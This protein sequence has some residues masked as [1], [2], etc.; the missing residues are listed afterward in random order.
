MAYSVIR[1]GHAARPH[2]R[3]T[4]PPV[5]RPEADGAPPIRG[6]IPGWMVAIILLAAVVPLGFVSGALARVTFIAGCSALGWYA[7]RQSAAIHL[8]TALTLFCFAPFVRRIIDLSAGFDPTGLM[9]VGPLMVLLA[10]AFDLWNAFI[11]GRPFAN[12]QIVPIVI[13][14]ACTLYAGTLS[15]FKWDLLNTASGL[16]KGFSP[17][18]YA[19]ALLLKKESMESLLE[20]AASAFLVILPIMGIYGIYQYVDPPEW[21]R[22]WMQSAT[23]TSAG[24]PVPYGVRT[25]S[26]MNSPGAFGTFTGVGL[27]LVL[28]LR[29]GPT[30]L[31]LT[32]PA[33]IAF[34]L[35]MYRT[36][37]L[38]T[39]AVTGFCLLFS[40]TR[41]RAVGAIGASI[42]M[43]LIALATP[44]S[45]VIVERFNSFTEGSN[46][47]SARERLDEFIT[48]WNMPTSNLF[49]VGFSNIDVGV[50][51]TMPVDGVFVAC[52]LSM[53]IIV[54]LICIYAV[55][56]A[57]ANAIVAAFGSE[58][59]T[60]I[61]AG[62][63]A[64]GSI[65]HFPLAEIIA[66]EA[67]FLFWT[68]V[69][70]VQGPQA[71][72]SAVP[73]SAQAEP[74]PARPALSRLPPAAT[75][76][77]T[78]GMKGRGF[79]AQGSGLP[80]RASGQ[81]QGS[82]ARALRRWGQ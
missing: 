46:D 13:V 20:A 38:S 57:C 24:Q 49:G 68:F 42:I 4:I 34:M 39:A 66:G 40:A 77:A 58:R 52:W 2:Q 1:Q 19:G 80:A 25:F 8:Q 33:A 27:M 61:V 43:I 56:L 10:P 81:R 71:Q 15:L 12:R 64:L 30:A 73:R 53:G 59:R 50:A 74:P 18:I 17:L 82:G 22:Y 67:G 37:W 41:F 23:I 51:G 44:F 45:E 60:A 7:W 54:G 72:A 28:F 21:D 32:T 26:V 16:V 11:S 76:P 79:G 31:I 9:L 69:V 70:L 14:G 75:P 36:A 65:V 78:P 29:T 63:L 47:G 3:D 48:L 55:F 35:S 5:A 6:F 62:G